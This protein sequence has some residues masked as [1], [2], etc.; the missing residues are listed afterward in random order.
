MPK[1]PETM[2]FTFDSLYVYLIISVGTLSICVWAVYQLVAPYRNLERAVRNI[3]EDLNTPSIPERGSHEVRSVIRA[4]N[5]MQ[6]RLKNHMSEREYLAAALAH[7]LRTPLTR[8]K[9]RCELA[10]SRAIQPIVQDVREIEKIV[11]SV[12]EFSRSGIEGQPTEK[13]ELVS[14]IQDVCTKAS[15]AHFQSPENGDPLS[16]VVRGNAV[17][18][19]RA[20]TNLVD[21]AIRHAGT[22]VV[23]LE[24][25]GDNVS[26]IV[27]DE[28][29]GIPEA[30]LENV[31]KPFHRLESSRNRET[32]GTGLG[33]SIAD[34]IARA[35]KGTLQVQNRNPTGLRAVFTLPVLR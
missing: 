13:I 12:L 33:L 7:G 35:H 30:E 9:I 5:T 2:P 26:I 4:I 29:K 10:N 3:G 21:N 22:A 34:N 32:G 8:I 15:Q 17:F 23:H 27:E 1:S 19:S 6:A 28:G 14:L 16:V 18:L 20:I 25:Q 31:L 11:N 24:M